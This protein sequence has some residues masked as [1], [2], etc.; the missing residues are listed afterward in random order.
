MASLRRWQPSFDLNF[1]NEPGMR[2][3][4]QEY[5]AEAGPVMSAGVWLAGGGETGD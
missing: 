2:R 5:L 1:E 4:F 3:G